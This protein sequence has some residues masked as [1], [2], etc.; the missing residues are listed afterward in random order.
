[1]ESGEAGWKGAEAVLLAQPIPFTL[2]TCQGWGVQ[3]WQHLVLSSRGEWLETGKEPT[4]R[5]GQWQQDRPRPVPILTPSYLGVLNEE[6]SAVAVGTLG[7]L[8]AASTADAAHTAL[9]AHAIPVTCCR[10]QKQRG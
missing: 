3:S 2:P 5:L 7:T 1:M 10:G 6:A 9:T 4:Q 8:P